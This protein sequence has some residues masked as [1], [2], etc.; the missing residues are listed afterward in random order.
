MIGPG[1]S[2]MDERY[3]ADVLR[4]W[5]AR[6]APPLL[7]VG[8]DRPGVRTPWIDTADLVSVLR[9]WK[10]GRGPRLPLY[11]LSGDL[12]SLDD[13][14]VVY[15]SWL[16][17][18]VVRVVRVDHIVAVIEDSEIDTTCVRWAEVFATEAET[19]KAHDRI[20]DEKCCVAREALAQ[21]PED[22]QRGALTEPEDR[23]YR[24]K[25]S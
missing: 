6:E 11:L 2:F 25:P 22:L 4:E 7:Y 9:R 24:P 10:S 5:D 18:P 15:P 23:S 16:S 3:V 20:F 12:S 19:R 1:E 21:L 8:G 14:D 13:H 17:G